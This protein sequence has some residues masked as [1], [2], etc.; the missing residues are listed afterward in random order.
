MK[1]FCSVSAWETKTF[2]GFEDDVTQTYLK[3]CENDRLWLNLFI[4]YIVK[5]EKCHLL[6]HTACGTED[7]SLTFRVGTESETT[8][9]RRKR[10]L[11]ER[12]CCFNDKYFCICSHHISTIALRYRGY[13]SNAFLESHY[14]RTILGAVV[15]ICFEP[16]SVSDVCCKS[17]FYVL[18]LHLFI[19]LGDT[20]CHFLEL[21][22][23]RCNM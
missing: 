8:T 7:G 20:R 10:F 22:F 4:L 13:L 12:S 17:W 23:L 6:K 5:I 16:C 1:Y 15:V 14:K 3:T 11:P 9:R 21:W 19:A 2:F 18:E